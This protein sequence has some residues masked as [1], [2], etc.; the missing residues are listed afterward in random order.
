MDQ[1]L[2][3]L[4]NSVLESIQQTFK[5]YKQ[6]SKAVLDQTM[7]STTRIINKALVTDPK[8][9]ETDTDLRFLIKKALT[10][11]MTLNDIGL[12]DNGILNYYRNYA[13]PIQK[14]TVSSLQPLKIG[15]HFPNVFI[16]GMVCDD[17]FDNNDARLMCLLFHNSTSQ[18]MNAYYA[19]SIAYD[20]KNPNCRFK[21]NYI[22]EL[23]PCSFVISSLE[24]P[25]TSKTM[26]ECKYQRLINT[27]SQTCRPN[28]HINVFC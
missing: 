27:A 11:T 7:L 15:L 5:N 12:F 24:C 3:E 10:Q 25:S 6:E 28:E 22:N 8:N 20:Q 23:V 18:S 2:I 16:E 14:I 9:N 4:K 1:K 19:Q 26:N 17:Q 21:T 13:T